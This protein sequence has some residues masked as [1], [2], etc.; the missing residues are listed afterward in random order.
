MRLAPESGYLYL[1][2]LGRAYYF[3]GDFEQARISLQSALA[4]NPEFIDAHVYLAAA[5]A[6]SGDLAAAAW[7]AEE[8][9][10]LQPAFSTR[11]WLATNPTANA[12]LRE[13][14]VASLAELGL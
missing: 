6:A 4:R 8:I 13:K 11:G 1:M 5:H 10:A 14:L 9:R 12:A 2:L 3:L 7:E